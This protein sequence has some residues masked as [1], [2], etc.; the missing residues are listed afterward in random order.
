MPYR[1]LRLRQIEPDIHQKIPICEIDDKQSKLAEAQ[2]ATLGFE[3]LQYHFNKIDTILSAV[4]QDPFVMECSQVYL[5]CQ[6]WVN[7]S[8]GKHT[9][10][11]QIQGLTERRGSREEWT[12]SHL[13]F[14]RG[15]L[16][17]TT[18][19]KATYTPTTASVSPAATVFLY[20]KIISRAGT[21]YK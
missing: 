15:Y 7:W 10:M 11:T 17:T 14:S 12:R 19:V 5:R 1:S 18:N 9:R 8:D 2:Y 6:G 13:F 4:N 16:P 21:Y 20:A 3:S